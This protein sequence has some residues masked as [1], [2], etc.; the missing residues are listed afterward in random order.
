MKQHTLKYITVISLII[1]LSN[2]QTPGIKSLNAAD[3][4]QNDS[5]IKIAS[6]NMQIFG[7]TK[8]NRPN[9]LTVLSKI[10]SNFD[11]IALQEVGSNKS[12]T[13]DENCAEIMD[14]YV[15]KINEIAGKKIYSYIRGNQYAIVFRTDKIRV[16]QYTVYS[17]TESFSYS[18]LIANFKTLEK[19]SNF[20]FSLITIHTS[21]KLA[22]YEITAL[23][24]VIDETRNLYS[25][26]DVICLGDY[27]ADGS[28]YN[29]GSHEWLAGFDPE[30]YITGIPNSFD[31]TI[32]DSENTYDRIEMT[33]SLNSDYTGN[34]GVFRFGEFY[35]ITEC[36]GGKTTAGTE[37]AVSDHYPVWCEYHTDRDTD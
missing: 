31:T 15:A 14:T 25:E 10:A 23:K 29:E 20:D 9:T 21:P 1:L 30:I 35:N 37:K 7:K 6:F 28:Y 27:N 16:K 36:E 2:I 24:T 19:D 34:S 12:S 5:V 18:P 11:I 4:S 8:L 26:E 17:G 33:E 22:G 32:A 13:S 3:I